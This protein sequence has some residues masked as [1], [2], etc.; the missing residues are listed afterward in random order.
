MVFTYFESLHV[1]EAHSIKLT[2][3]TRALYNVCEASVGILRTLWNSAVCFLN[4]T[5]TQC[6]LHKALLPQNT[7]LTNSSPLALLKSCCFQLAFQLLPLCP[8]TSLPLTFN[9]PEEQKLFTTYSH[10]SRSPAHL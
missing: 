1:L 8:S 4:S 5:W 2:R 7:N 9:S 6:T 10:T 3:V